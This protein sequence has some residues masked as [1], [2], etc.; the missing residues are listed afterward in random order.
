MTIA[1]IFVFICFG[2]WAVLTLGVLLCAAIRP[3]IARI[4]HGRRLSVSN[5]Y[6]IAMMGAMGAWLAMWCF[7]S[8]Y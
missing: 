8:M 2:L 3:D 1:Q 5:P 4:G 6:D 7:R